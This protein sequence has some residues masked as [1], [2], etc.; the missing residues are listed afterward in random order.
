MDIGTHLR[1]ARQRR[2]VTL[3]QIADSTKLSTTTLQHIERNELDRLP[4]GIYTK[5]CLRA[6]A[7]E[8]GVNPEEVVNE[9][10]AQFPAA[11][12]AEEQPIVRAPAIENQL[13]GRRLLPAAA[14]IVLAL[15]I[16]GS[17]QDSAE[18]PVTSS[19]E[20]VQASAPI[21]SLVT[22][23]VASGALPATE[24]QEWGLHLEIQPAGEC[25][26][27]AEADGRL[28]LYRLLQSGERVTVIAREELVL[29]V[30]DPAMFAYT[31]NGVSGRPF[32]E[33]GKP[34]TVQIT[35][36]NYRTFRA[37]SAPEMLRRGASASVI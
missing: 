36:S 31:L 30:G 17:L 25:W 29:R 15:V 3:R 1:E 9:Y 28:V 22:E 21:E 13:D 33:A 2:G 10:L 16:Y 26:V 8:V 5:G 14:A 37:G 23:S 11:R 12:A 19:R 32:G 18:S 24:R 35:E 27:S 34:V 20:L 4:G 7:A 6:Y